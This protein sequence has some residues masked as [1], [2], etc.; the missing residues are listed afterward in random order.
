MMTI[1]TMQQVDKVLEYFRDMPDWAKNQWNAA[2]KQVKGHKYPVEM[3]STFPYENKECG[4]CVGTHLAFVLGL[5]SQPNRIT[6][7]FFH[8]YVGKN[9]FAN[10][11]GIEPSQLVRHITECSE[12]LGWNCPMPFGYTE[13]EADPFE[14]LSKVALRCGWQYK[15]K[16][17]G[18]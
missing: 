7:P 16:R 6:S 3:H 9:G 10:L 1:E 5:E 8:F 17:E 12:E 4:V 14:V 11:L 2:G 13:W 15:D 18:V